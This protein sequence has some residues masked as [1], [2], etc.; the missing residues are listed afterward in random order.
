MLVYT[1]SWKS[2]KWEVCFCICFQKNISSLQKTIKKAQ[3]ETEAPTK[4]WTERYTFTPWKINRI[5]IKKC[6]V[7]F[8]LDVRHLN[9]NLDQSSES[10]PLE[11]LAT[12]LSWTNRK[13]TN[14]HLIS[15]AHLH[16]LHLMMKLFNLMEFPLVICVLLSVE[17]FVALKVFQF[18]SHN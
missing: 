11:R 8:V 16:M 1:I 14:L 18:F 10:W 2:Q 9:S 15:C 12:Q 7:E 5:I 6:S 13:K 3:V 4:K 17:N